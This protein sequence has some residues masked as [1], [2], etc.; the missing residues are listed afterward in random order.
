MCVHLLSTTHHKSEVFGTKALIK[1]VAHPYFLQ[2]DLAEDVDYSRAVATLKGSV[3]RF[4][5]PK[6]CASSIEIFTSSFTCTLHAA[7][8]RKVFCTHVGWHW[9]PV[10]NARHLACSLSENNGTRSCTWVPRRQCVCGAKPALPRPT[11]H[12]NNSVRNA[13][14]GCKN[15]RSA[16]LWTGHAFV[17]ACVSHLQPCIG[18]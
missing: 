8:T 4:V 6:V 10:T 15:R 3:V 2:L 12:W 11:R 16:H 17:R 18:L 9:M 1:V 13:R 7:C 14:P 5:L